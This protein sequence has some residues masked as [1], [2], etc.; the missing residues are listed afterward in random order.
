MPR[1]ADLVRSQTVLAGFYIRQHQIVSRSI[2][3]RAV[4]QD[5]F[6]VRMPERVIPELS[7]PLEARAVRVDDLDIFDTRQFAVLV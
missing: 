3:E 4:R 7:N 6:S 5:L 2:L 1:S